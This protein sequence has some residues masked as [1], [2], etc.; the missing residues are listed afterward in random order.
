MILLLLYII[1][2][3]SAHDGKCSK[4]GNIQAA[5]TGKHPGIASLCKGIA[6]RRSV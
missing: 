3:D 1:V 2:V 5:L 6:T 4:K